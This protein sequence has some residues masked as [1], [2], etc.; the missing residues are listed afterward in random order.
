MADH[1]SI[2]F[3]VADE[4]K[5]EALEMARRFADIGYSLVATSGTAQYLKTAG[6]YVRSW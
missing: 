3:T 6:L 1:G 4:D 5:A 2:L